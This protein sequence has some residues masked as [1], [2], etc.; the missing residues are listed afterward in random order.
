MV[1][2]S[3]QQKA[4]STKDRQAHVE[5]EARLA[6]LTNQAGMKLTLTK[7]VACRIPRLHNVWL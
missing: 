7:Q 6:I 3:E 2:E 4:E 5:E 1:A